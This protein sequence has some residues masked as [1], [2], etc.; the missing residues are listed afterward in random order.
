MLIKVIFV[1]RIISLLGILPW[2]L[3]CNSCMSV[4]YVS[5]IKPP[6]EMRYHSGVRFNIVKSNFSYG[7]PAVRFQLNQRLA[8][9][10]LMET[11]KELYP[12]L[13]SREHAALPVK[14]RGHI[15][16]SRNLLLLIALE[17]ATLA[18]VYGVFPGPMFETYSFSLQT[19]VEDQFSGTIFAS[20]FDEFK[21]KTVGWISLLTP[22]GLLP[23][24]GKTEEPRDNTFTIGL[25]SGISIH[26]SACMKK[27]IIRSVV[28]ALE[29][30]DHKKLA[31]AYNLRKKLE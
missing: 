29:S 8:P 27:S 20:A 31:E 5:T 28:K 25:A 9:N 6:A 4:R 17:V 24:P 14:I 23:I 12:D 18:I 30:A 26:H 21:T 1:K 2:I 3:L 15:K 16:F 22:L 13:F 11:A 10:M 19:Q 7:K